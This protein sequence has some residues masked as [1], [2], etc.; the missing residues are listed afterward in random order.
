[1]HLIITFQQLKPTLLINEVPLVTDGSS[2]AD[3]IVI[4]ATNKFFFSP[5]SSSDVF[6]SLK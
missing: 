4:A 2:Y 3:Y 5:I 1:M 6:F